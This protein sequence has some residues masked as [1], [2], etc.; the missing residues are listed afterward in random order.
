MSTNRCQCGSFAINEHSHGRIKGVDS[1]SCDVCYWR[2]RATVLLDQ[3][4][5][6][7]EVLKRIDKYG[8]S[9][10]LYDAHEN[11]L[12]CQDAHALIAEIEATK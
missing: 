7:L 10:G 11:F 3:R 12:A 8:G 2:N 9:C 1:I 4:D 5:R 6:L